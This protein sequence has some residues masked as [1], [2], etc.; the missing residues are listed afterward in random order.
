MSRFLVLLSSLIALSTP[1]DS[2]GAVYAIDDSL[3]NPLSCNLIADPVAL[4]GRATDQIDSAGLIAAFEAHYPSPASADTPDECLLLHARLE[5]MEAFKTREAH[6][7]ERA[8]SNERQALPSL[9]TLMMRRF[10]QD[11]DVSQ[12]QPIIQGAEILAASSFPEDKLVPAPSLIPVRCGDDDVCHRAFVAELNGP[13]DPDRL[14]EIALQWRA[15]D[16]TA[17]AKRH[18]AEEAEAKF[19][20]RTPAQIRFLSILPQIKATT[21]QL[22]NE[23]LRLNGPE[24]KLSRAGA[25]AADATRSA[26]DHIFSSPDIDRPG[27]LPA[28]D[29]LLF[30]RELCR[31]TAEIGTDHL[32]E[33]IETA[34]ALDSIA[35]RHEPWERLSAAGVDDA[36]GNGI[37]T[38]GGDTL[39]VLLFYT[40][41]VA[42][43]AGLMV[44]A[45]D[46]LDRSTLRQA[47]I[48]LIDNVVAEQEKA[49]KTDKDRAFEQRKKLTT[50]L[51][52]SQV[53]AESITCRDSTANFESRLAAFRDGKKDKKLR[54]AQ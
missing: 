31:W 16:T 39:P 50:F 41:I 18:A 53:V 15:R 22:I 25:D 6:G 1:Y 54:C 33:A 42:A 48:S 47:R 45:Q 10:N 14:A 11:A 27:R 19:G 44:E 20:D 13:A 21:Q 12:I 30:L 51:L 40:G 28:K 32:G 35:A 52:L 26:I 2:A 3:L 49:V 38:I 7:G 17:S 36:S 34:Y 24:E 23:T 9:R 4:A 5:A 43:K 8:I 37:A 29:F 46:L